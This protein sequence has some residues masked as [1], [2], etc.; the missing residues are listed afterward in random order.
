M[1]LLD[2][3]GGIADEWLP[4]HVSASLQRIADKPV[5]SANPLGRSARLRRVCRLA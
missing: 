5:S 3:R 2:M 4:V 1:F